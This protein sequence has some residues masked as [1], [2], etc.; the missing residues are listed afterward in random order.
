MSKTEVTLNEC[1]K[2]ICKANMQLLNALT[3]KRA[4]A[5]MLRDVVAE[6]REVANKLEK[7]FKLNNE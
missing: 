3:F 2:Q 6:L 1:F 5:A 7:E 4:S